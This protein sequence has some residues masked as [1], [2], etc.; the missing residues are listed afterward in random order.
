M[1]LCVLCAAPLICLYNMVMYCTSLLLEWIENSKVDA[2]HDIK[3]TRKTEFGTKS[4]HALN[5][6]NKNVRMGHLHTRRLPQKF[7]S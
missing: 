2:I 6:K 4:H 3:S 7:I 5:F 1:L